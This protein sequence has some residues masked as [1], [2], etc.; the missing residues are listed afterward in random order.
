MSLDSG[1]KVAFKRC[2]THEDFVRFALLS[3]DNNPIHTDP[4]FSA[5]T[6]FGRPVAH[7]AFLFG[8]L[9]SAMNALFP[10]SGLLLLYQELMFP[11]PTYAGEE[12]TVQVEITGL[13]REK[14]Q[15]ELSMIVLR[16]NGEPGCQGLALV[17]F[18]PAERWPEA[19]REIPPSPPSEGSVLKGFRLGESASLQRT[20]TGED[21]QAYIEL[22]G[23][24]NPLYM[25]AE[26]AC[27]RGLKAPLLPP[28]LLGALFSCLL[29]AHLP[30]WGTNYLKQRLLFLGPAHTGE[31]LEA[32]VE[33]VRIRPEKELI[34]LRTA[35]RKE[36]D[37][38]IADGEALVLT[39]DVKPR[40][41]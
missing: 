32:T 15:A 25:D 22:T 20:F 28:P 21:V 18:G 7:G 37:N 12:V 35:C 23:D 10:S 39:R 1:Q 30:G 8:L 14:S 40:E 6:R 29:G 5:R 26:L 17:H 3:G 13:N 24:A 4:E 41:A 38:L 16:P 27:K 19:S 36:G 9:A 34:N 33:I 31:K 2:L 11:T